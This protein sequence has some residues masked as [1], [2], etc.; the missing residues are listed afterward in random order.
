MTS[1]VGRP[2]WRLLLSFLNE[3]PEREFSCDECFSMLEYLAD[4]GAQNA[5]GQDHLQLLIRRHLSVCPQ[6]SEHYMQ[7]IESMEQLVS[8]NPP[9]SR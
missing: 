5:V 6:C 2:L 4:I 7:V 8:P 3:R 9:G 1:T